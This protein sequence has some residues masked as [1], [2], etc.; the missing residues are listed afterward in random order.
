EERDLLQPMVAFHRLAATRS[1][2]KHLA[3]VDGRVA[4]EGSSSVPHA[5]LGVEAIL[6]DDVALAGGVCEHLMDV[7]VVV[8][9]VQTT[10]S[11]LGHLYPAHARL[12]GEM[13][14]T[15]A[16]VTHRGERVSLPIDDTRFSRGYRD[17]QE[18]RGSDPR[19]CDRPNE[20][21]T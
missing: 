20:P 19:R 11:D 18:Q 7:V 10:R 3:G 13:T 2:R 17:R 16:L 4:I 21:G 6:V 9:G 5:N 8:E 14:T 15:G 1:D 12:D